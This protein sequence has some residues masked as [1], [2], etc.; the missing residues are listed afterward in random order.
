MGQ[1]GSTIYVAGMAGIDPA[2]QQLA[3]PAIQDQTRQALRNCLA[4]RDGGTGPRCHQAGRRTAE[5]A[6]VDHHD[7][8]GR[9]LIGHN[10]PEYPAVLASPDV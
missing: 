8:A 9:G 10:P 2:T 1:A 5:R 7:R 3:G 4:I 6:C